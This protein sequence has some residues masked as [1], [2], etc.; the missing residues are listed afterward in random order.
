MPAF[1]VDRG[2]PGTPSLIPELFLGERSVALS[3]PEV[4]QARQEVTRTENTEERETRAVWR[5]TLGRRPLSHGRNNACG[6]SVQETHGD[7]ECSQNRNLS[8][9]PSYISKD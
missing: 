5:V 2:K 1:R 4:A 3:R 9:R 6:L 8:S 7:L